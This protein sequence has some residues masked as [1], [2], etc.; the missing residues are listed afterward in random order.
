MSRVSYI[1]FIGGFCLFF[2]VI[3]GRVCYINIKIGY[4]K[5]YYN[6]ILKLFVFWNWLGFVVGDLYG[7]LFKVRWVFNMVGVLSLDGRD[8]WIGG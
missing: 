8:L 1:E 7:D 5:L 2:V 4:F 3:I 6:W